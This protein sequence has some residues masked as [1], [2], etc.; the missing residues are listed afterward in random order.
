MLL[1][2]HR[3][4]ERAIEFY[5]HFRTLQLNRKEVVA[6][7]QAEMECVFNIAGSHMCVSVAPP[8]SLHAT[9][10]PCISA[11]SSVPLYFCTSVLLY[12]CASVPLSTR[13]SASLYL[14]ADVPLYFCASMH[15]CSLCHCVYCAHDYFRTGAA[16]LR[17]TV[18]C[19]LTPMRTAPMRRNNTTLPMLDC[20]VV[21]WLG[22]DAY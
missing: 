10:W 14:C 4:H 11:L 3:R 12:L 8:L 22:R 18:L 20:L 16:L 7:R 15:L 1:L 9:L 21:G 2:S 17:S 6:N 5:N 13:T 19:L